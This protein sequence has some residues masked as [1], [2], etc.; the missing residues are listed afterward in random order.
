MAENL[1]CGETSESWII[2]NDDD[3]INYG[4]G[5]TNEIDYN[6]QLFAKDDNFG[7][8]GSI[9]MMGSSSSSLSEDRIK[10]ML[11]R[12]IEFCPGTD[13]VKRLLSGDL[14]LSVRNQALDWILKVCAHYHFGHLCICL[15]M[16]YLDRFLTSYE[17]PKDKD[18]AAQ[19]L[20]VSCLSLASK[21][22]ETDVPHIV[23]L[24]VEDPKFVFEAKTIKR[25]ELLVVTTLNWRLQALTPF[26]FIDY[27]V[28]KISGH[29]SEN[30]IYRSS[31]FILNTTKA[32]EFLDFRPS[33]IAAA[34]AVSVS[35][36][37]ET[38][39]IDEEKALS[40]L[41][42]VKQERVKR[43]LNLMRSLTG[44]ENVRGT[45]LS[46][47]Q[48]RVAVR[49]VPASP[50]GVLEATCLSYRSEERTVESCTNSSQSSPD[51][52]NNN[53]NSNKRRRKQ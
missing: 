23:D 18:W 6:H 7:G 31:R 12:E 14:D 50:V 40:S 52:N 11:V 22:E 43:C 35:I 4:G 45:S 5:F 27:F 10:E 36:S 20:A 47:E 2:D 17:L 24:Q 34:A 19:L 25:M 37:G 26:S 41:I 9:P 29:V 15:S 38:E 46:Q 48:A 51:N 21:M 13:Y 8:N 28:D 16:N 49:A 33:E 1:A 53:N 32:I 44:E 42:Y 39:C 30:L 3:D